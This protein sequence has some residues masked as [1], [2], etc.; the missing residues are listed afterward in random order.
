MRNELKGHGFLQ[1]KTL[2]K[3]E[4]R[5]LHGRRLN[6]IRAM[7][8]DCGL[9]TADGNLNF[10]RPERTPE[11]AQETRPFS[12]HLQDDDLGRI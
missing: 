8:R 2:F 11:P 4:T 10:G 5:Y 3:V 12:G 7:G 1:R 6:V 9:S